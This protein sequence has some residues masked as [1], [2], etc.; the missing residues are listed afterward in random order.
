MNCLQIVQ[1]GIASS[2]QDSGRVGTLRMGISPSGAMDQPALF[3]GQHQLGHHND[4]AAI[5]MAY[6]DLIATP[7]TARD[8][9]VTGAPVKLTIN[10]HAVS[11]KGIHRIEAGQIFRIKATSEGI[12]SYLHLS[13]GV[14]TAPQANSRS[15]SRK[16]TRRS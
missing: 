11:S 4:E 14:A 13:G 3:S 6:A 7:T 12:Y 1:A 9:V 2:V 8:I 15:T 10:Q 16:D 5:E